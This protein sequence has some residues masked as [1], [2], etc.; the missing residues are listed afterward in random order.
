MIESWLGR[1]TVARPPEQGSVVLI[2]VCAVGFRLSSFVPCDIGGLGNTSNTLD[3]GT[4]ATTTS[5]CHGLTRPGPV[6]CMCT[7][8]NTCMLP[9]QAIRTESRRPEICSGG[10]PKPHH[11]ALIT[12]TPLTSLIR[13]FPQL[14]LSSSP[15][16]NAPAQPVPSTD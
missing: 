4:A 9:T 14:S 5:E 10:F 15:V 2:S 6:P 8:S 7:H 16:E 12:P 3:P 11:A 1:S 13:N